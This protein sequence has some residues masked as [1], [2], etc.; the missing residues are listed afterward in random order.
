MLAAVLPFL[1]IT[2]T[3]AAGLKFSFSQGKWGHEWHVSS[4]DRP[5]ALP[6]ITFTDEDGTVW[7]VT[8]HVVGH[9]A[10]EIQVVIFVSAQCAHTTRV[11]T[12]RA[13]ATVGA[14]PFDS[15]YDFPKL[16]SIDQLPAFS[17]TVDQTG[18]PP[19]WAYSGDKILLSSPFRTG[20]VWT[21]GSF[22]QEVMDLAEADFRRAMES[23]EQS[24]IV[25][26]TRY[27]WRASIYMKNPHLMSYLGEEESGVLKVSV[28]RRWYAWKPRS[29]D[30]DC[31]FARP[32]GEV[33]DSTFTVLLAE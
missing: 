23:E 33:W 32:G 15:Y 27:G 14:V 18:Q 9:E 4:V 12:A 24:E 19:V 5:G 31:T 22:S 28:V 10:G 16:S 20:G 6:D 2:E 21:L 13:P 25:C 8:S 26:R 29:V 30:I 11:L 1:M 3:N 17:L 7:R